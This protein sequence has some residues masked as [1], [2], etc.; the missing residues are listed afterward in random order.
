MANGEKTGGRQKGSL[1]KPKRAL[2]ALLRER[3]PNYHPVLEMAK[4]AH[5]TDD[6]GLAAQ[7]HKEIAQYV[8]PKLKAMELTGKDGGP[9]QITRIE[10]VPLSGNSKS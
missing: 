5:E 2:L 1:N 8:E 4:I 7:M 3:Y 10:L 9:V 6:P